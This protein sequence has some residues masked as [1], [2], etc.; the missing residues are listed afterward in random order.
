LSKNERSRLA[1]S[2]GPPRAHRAVVLSKAEARPLQNTL[3][4]E[5]AMDGEATTDV[6]A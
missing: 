1:E 5:T 3:Y 4:G 6:T 2:T